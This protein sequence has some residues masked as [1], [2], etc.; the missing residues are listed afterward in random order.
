MMQ[1]QSAPERAAVAFLKEFGAAATHLV[2]APG[3]VNLIGEHTDYNGLPV[4]PVAL[5][6]EAK[7]AFRPRPDGMVVLHDVDE[8][9]PPLEFEIGPAISPE[10]AGHWGNYVK[11][12]ANELARRF[13]VWRGF[14]G[15]LHS[16][17]PVAAGLSS[18]SAIVNAI[19]LALAH[20]NEVPVEARA[21]A[22]LMADAERY[23]GTLGGAMDQ[24]ISLGG[25]S[26]C[27]T[28]ITFGPLRLQHVQIPADWSFVVADTGVRAEKAGAAQNTYNLRRTECEDALSRVIEDLVRADRVP[29]IPSS[30]SALLRAMPVDDVLALA[31]DV[32]EGNLRRRFRHVVTEAARVNEAV[33][34]MR[35]ADITGFGTLMDAS[36]GSLRTDFHVSTAELDEL[37]AIAREG[38]AFGARLTGAGLGGCIVAL[39]D[40]T[41]VGTVLETLVGEY[42][43][44]RKLTE[45]LD[46]RLFVAVA[47][48]GASVQAL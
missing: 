7:V 48:S 20:I 44:P 38:G 28:K 39:A 5:Q 46:A 23:T 43:E 41:T 40:R 4:L 13:A 33:D 19:G 42:Y 45:D 3:R 21:F 31:E 9:F 34:R 26:G 8:E 47:S 10:A 15:V 6:R 35:G 24:A 12:P 14:E 2:R 1:T 30:Y 27:A 22:E 16:D 36:H 17:I 18:S 29:L 32:L 25:R 11:A 37:T